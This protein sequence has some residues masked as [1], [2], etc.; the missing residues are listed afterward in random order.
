MD[1]AK[2]NGESPAKMEILEKEMVRVQAK[3][4]G[5]KQ[6]NPGLKQMDRNKV[7]QVIHS[8]IRDAAKSAGNRLS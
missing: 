3:L 6:E 5:M 7:G 8:A 2:M 1:P 4:D